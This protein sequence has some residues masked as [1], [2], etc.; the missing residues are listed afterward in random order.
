MRLRIAVVVL[1]LG[2]FAVVHPA[3]ARASYGECL[4]DHYIEWWLVSDAIFQ[5][6]L[7]DEFPI[8]DEIKGFHL[9][10]TRVWK[11]KAPTVVKTYTDAAAAH[12]SRVT[13]VPRFRPLGAEYSFGDVNAQRVEYLIHYREGVPVVIE[14]EDYCTPRASAE[15]FAGSELAA[16]RI[17]Y[18]SER[19][20]TVVMAAVLALILRAAWRRRAVG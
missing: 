11:G 6:Y 13:S 15:N 19:V 1:L 8:D 20:L 10:V 2:L 17:M 7:G 18:Y 5:A 9:E 16:A 4:I 12:W 14:D 3:P